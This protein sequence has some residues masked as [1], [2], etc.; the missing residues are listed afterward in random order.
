MYIS[1]FESV[2]QTLKI[3]YNI[4]GKSEAGLRTDSG[5]SNPNH[6]LGLFP[7][8]FPY[9]KG[10]FE[11]ARPR[12]VS[13]EAHSKWSM[14]YWDKHFRTDLNFIFQIF[15]IMQKRNICRSS[16]LQMKSSIY[17]R[18]ETAIRSLKPN[19]LV[20]ASQEETRRAPFSNPAVQALRTQLTAVRAK[21]QGTDES[22]R[23]IRSKIWGNDH[24]VQPPNVMGHNKPQ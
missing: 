24:Y 23:T 5:P 6:L 7:V 9:G 4:I 13:Y 19:D 22:R 15:G 11:V 3:I 20:K 21:V 2:L 12:D 16:V 10:G 18:H 8:L 14:Q 1:S 17:H